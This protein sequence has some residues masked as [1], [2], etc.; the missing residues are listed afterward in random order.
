MKMAHK[1]LVRNIAFAE[2]KRG[3]SITLYVKKCHR[4]VL[5]KF[6][7]PIHFTKSSAHAILSWMKAGS[8]GKIR[9]SP[10]AYNYVNVRINACMHI[11]M[12]V[13]TYVCIYVCIYARSYGHIYFVSVTV[14]TDVPRVT[15]HLRLAVLSGHP[16]DLSLNPS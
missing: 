2:C 9:L 10:T 5:R 14:F 3:S 8:P 12:H 1:K 13:S 4:M 11:R 6:H 7:S 15:S 16:H